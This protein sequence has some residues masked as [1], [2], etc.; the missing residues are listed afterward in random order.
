MKIRL[1]LLFL[2]VLLTQYVFSNNVP[3]NFYMKETYKRF[4]KTLN[5]DDYTIL[6]FVNNNFISV[7]ETRS[8]KMMF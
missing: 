4:E 1:L 2:S 8:K 3:S 6:K 7:V 5:D